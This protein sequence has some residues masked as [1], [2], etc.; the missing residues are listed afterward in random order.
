LVGEGVV[1]SG[2]GGTTGG[3]VGALVGDGV[4]GSGVGG[5]KGFFKSE[6][7]KEQLAI[8]ISPTKGREL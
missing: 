7:K 5:L 3:S 6:L 2:V 8:T 1:G 4:V